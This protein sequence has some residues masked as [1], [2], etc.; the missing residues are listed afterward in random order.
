MKVFVL[1]NR[2]PLGD[3]V[4]LSDQPDLFRRLKWPASFRSLAVPGRLAPS[5]RE[6]IFSNLSHLASA[7][8]LLLFVA[9]ERVGIRLLAASARSSSSQDFTGNGIGR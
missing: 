3:I 5:C 9:L 7:C 2:I 4:S 8:A 6:L 1:Y